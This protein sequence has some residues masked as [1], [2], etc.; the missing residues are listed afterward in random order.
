MS[1]TSRI[2]LNKVADEVVIE[3]L[4]QVLPVVEGA[5][6]DYFMVGAF[7]RDVEL[8]A[9]GHPDPPARKTKD[10]DLAVMVGS[11]EEYGVLMTALANLPDMDKNANEPYRFTF[12]NAYEIDF[13]PFGSIADEMGRVELKAKKTFVL[14]IPGFDA[15]KPYAE[16]IETEEGLRLK[17]SSL[18]GVVLL[19]LFAW[20][21]RPEREKDIQDIDHIIKHFL[22]LH[23]EEISA[24]PDDLFGRYE[25]ET[26]IFEQCVSARFVGRQIGGM[27]SNH[28]ALKNRLLR[29]LDEQSSGYGMARLMSPEFLENNQRI[30]RALFDGMNDA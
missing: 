2:L 21:D 7:A 9:K 24:E 18:P 5:G 16:T 14:D 6:I 28:M 25:N 8:L 11:L 13:L 3:L 19:K 20:Q 4:R 26:T 12:R 1:S 15:V 30:I 23:W 10:I 17:V 27:L 29:L 22:P